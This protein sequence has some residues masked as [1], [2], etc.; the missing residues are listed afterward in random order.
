MGC[1]TAC[2][3][4]FGGGPWFSRYN[5]N[6][7]S[8]ALIKALPET[9]PEPPRSPPFH[10]RGSVE[11]PACGAGPAVVHRLALAQGLSLCGFKPALWSWHVGSTV[12][13]SVVATLGLSCSTACE[14]LVPRP[15]IRPS[16]PALQCGLFLYQITYHTAP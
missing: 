7:F 6:S 4:S 15:V 11:F 10:R 13:G 3:K 12:R 8:L 14:I 5:I 9:Q 2:L 1:S 16:S